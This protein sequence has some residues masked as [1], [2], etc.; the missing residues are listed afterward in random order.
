[1][2]KHSIIIL[3]DESLTRRALMDGVRWEALG[4]GEIYEAASAGAAKKIMKEHKVDLALIDIEMPEENGLEFLQWLRDEFHSQI[5]CAFLT[6]H[7]S[8]DYAQ[9]A[10]RL[11]VIDY[12]LKPMDYSEVEKLILKMIGK[13]EEEMEQEQFSRYGRQWVQEKIEEGHRHEK[14]SQDINEIIENMIFYIRGHLSEKLSLTGLAL[15][16]GMNPN[17]LNKVFKNHT[18]ETVNKFIIREK[19]NLAAK[20]IQEGD[21]KLY[22]IAE[23]LGY[24]NYANFVNMFKKTYGMPPNLYNEGKDTNR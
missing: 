3:D 8:F 16:A 13:T 1:M 18:G 12:L 14:T 23:F 21:L 15:K 11:G 17:Y 19:M 2:E 22:A 7:A 20:M 4:I 5:P 9:E 10:I 24:D 6:C